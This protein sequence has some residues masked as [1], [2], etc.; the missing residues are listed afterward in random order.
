MG[1]AQAC[2]RRYV[3]I[4]TH[5]LRAGGVSELRTKFCKIENIL[6]VPSLPVLLCNDHCE[7]TGH[8]LLHIFLLLSTVWCADFTYCPKGENYFNYRILVSWF[9]DPGFDHIL[10]GASH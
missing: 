3:D 8:F 10:F 4:C 5:L 1:N 9:S 7:A 6:Q 2:S